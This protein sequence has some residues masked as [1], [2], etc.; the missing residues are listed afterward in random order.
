MTRDDVTYKNLSDIG[1]VIKGIDSAFWVKDV[2]N[3][4]CATIS[5]ENKYDVISYNRSKEPIELSEKDNAVRPFHMLWQFSSDKFM[6]NIFISD[7]P[8]DY[9]TLYANANRVYTDLV[10]GTIAGLQYG[11]YIRFDR[12]DNRGFAIDALDNLKED[13]DGMLYIL[14][15]DLEKQKRSVEEKLYALLRE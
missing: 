9:L 1:S 11:K 6:E 14:E 12:V 15:E 10:H 13:N 8:Y 3:P 7:T 5:T 2:Y 4:R